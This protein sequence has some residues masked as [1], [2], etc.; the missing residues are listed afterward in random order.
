MEGFSGSCPMLKWIEHVSVRSVAPV[1]AAIFF[2]L[3]CFSVGSTCVLAW[4]APGPVTSVQLQGPVSLSFA[5][6][7]DLYILLLYPFL[8]PVGGALGT[9]VLALLYNFVAR[10]VGRSG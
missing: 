4:L 6:M 2:F 9:V 8:S 7:P 1:S 10:R 5:E 3:G